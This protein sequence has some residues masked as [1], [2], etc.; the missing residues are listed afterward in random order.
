MAWQ[1]LSF[2]GACASETTA[3]TKKA[4]NNEKCLPVFMMVV[5]ENIFWSADVKLI[6]ENY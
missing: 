4:S 2:A 3:A 6:Q 1:A 5:A